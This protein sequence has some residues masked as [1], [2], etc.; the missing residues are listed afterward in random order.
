M[1]LGFAALLTLGAGQA[2]ADFLLTLAAGSPTGGGSD[3]TY[4]Y[5]V[6]LQ[7]NST[8]SPSGGGSNSSNIFTIYDFAGYIPGTATT[9]TLTGFSVVTAGQLLGVNVPTQAPPD[10][11]VVLNITYTDVSNTTANTGTTSMML[12]T[13]A[14]QSTLNVGQQTTFYSGSSQ[15][16]ANNALIAN[17]TA[18]LLGPLQ[19]VPEPASLAMLGTGLVAV[20]GLGLRRMKKTA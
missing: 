12:G 7:G 1:L 6:F 3:F 14:L 19:S 17:N 16:S 8:L 18:Q 4:T 5:N 10:S 11:N 9:G 15:N 2:R 20:L 13:I